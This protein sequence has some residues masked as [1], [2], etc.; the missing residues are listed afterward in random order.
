MTQAAAEL[1]AALDPLSVI[2]AIERNTL[3]WYRTL[4][5]YIPQAVVTDEADH[6]R[7][8]SPA[9]HPACNAVL[10]ARFHHAGAPQRV[11][12]VMADFKRL[13]LPMLWWLGPGS[14]PVDLAS[15]LIAAG[16]QQTETLHGMAA[17]LQ[18]SLP[19][20]VRAECEITEAAD[21]EDIAD[22]LVP[23]GETFHMGHEC[24][25]L[26]APLRNAVTS[27]GPLRFF[28]ARA[29]GLP[30]SSAVLFESADV[31]ALHYVATRPFARNR[32]FGSALVAHVT[33]VAAAGGY[34]VCVLHGTPLSA[35]MYRRLGYVEYCRL[36][37]FLWRPS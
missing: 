10:G 5:S 4:A 20:P 22:W 12:E 17:D 25:A 14:K 33:R 30:V 31:A 36:R 32:G 18:A 11:R 19:G 35:D 34:R 37:T 9:R 16:L 28:V 3:N 6:T 27:R 15:H 7:I 13:G 2:E 21:D 1:H 23:F 24:M 29:D 26:L 8:V